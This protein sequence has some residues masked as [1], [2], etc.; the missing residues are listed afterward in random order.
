[1]K[2]I[3]SQIIFTGFVLALYFAF[4]LVRRKEMRYKENKLFI[5]VCIWSALWSFGFFGVILQTDPGMGYLWRGIGMIGTFGFLISAQFLICHLSGVKKIYCY[6]TEGFSLLGI[7]LYFFVIRKDQVVYRLGEFGMT[8]SFEPTIWNNLYTWYTVLVAFNQFWLIMYMIFRPKAQRTKILG[9]K[10]LVV[11]AAMLL[12]MVLDTIFPLFGKP[13]IPGSTIGQFAGLAV[14]YHAIL[15]VNHSR[16]TIGNMSE[17]IYYSLDI[18]ILVYDAGKELRILNDKGFTFLGV[19]NMGMAQ[20]SVGELFAL[21]KAEAFS[22]EGNSQSIDTICLYNKKNCNLTINKIYDDYGDVIGYIIIVTDLSDRMKS[23]KRLE[24]AVN[25]ADHANKAKSIFLANMSHEIR[26]PMNAIIGFSELLL[27]KDLDS[28]IRGHVED[29]KFS[30]QNL[31]TIINDILDISK[32][33]SGKMELVESNY[34]TANLLNDVRL[35]IEPQVQKKNLQFEVS[36]DENLPNEMYGDKV[37]IRGILINILNNAVKY[38]REGLVKF[39]VL[40]KE[41][42]FNRI[43]LAFRVTDTGTGI[44]EENLATLFDKFERL[45]QKVHY[46]IEGSGLGLAIAKAYVTMMGGEIKVESRYGVGST[47]TIEIEQIVVDENPIEIKYLHGNEANKNADNFMLKNTKTLVVDDNPVNLKVA[48]GILHTY[49]C[50]VDVALSGADAID[51]CAECNYDIVFMDQMMPGM[52]GPEAMWQIRR[53]NDHYKAG[54]PGKII[55]LTANAIK[56]TRE[57]LMEQGF[58]EY[59]GKPLN[60]D[61]LEALLCKFI[62]E[63]NVLWKQKNE[64]NKVTETE[65]NH[66]KDE[67]K[68]IREALPEIDVDLGL[69]HCGGMLEDYLKVLAI[70]YKYGEKQLEELRQLWDAKD[71]KGYNIKVHSLKSTS[72]NIGAKEISEEAKR[73]EEAGLREDYEYIEKNTERL[74]G[75][76]LVIMKKVKGVLIHFGVLEDLPEEKREE[77]SL[78]EERMLRPMLMNVEKAVDA[79]DFSKVFMIL[80][81]LDNYRLPEGYDQII[82]RLNTMMEDLSVE[83]IKLLLKETLEQ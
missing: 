15:F 45:D 35:I 8:Y 54:G 17:F 40:I 57:A 36:Y 77:K 4:E 7:I 28:D 60:I 67:L 56:G 10:L 71:Y 32:I 11:E 25:E 6:L 58:D 49:G 37:R 47:F 9:K 48:Q 55:V 22:F 75:E 69:S 3:L 19:Y 27:K 44:K 29:I 81:E 1:M 20:T 34:Y 79:F 23:M 80:E 63:E 83:E 26:T 43:S 18:P 51:M 72:L 70:T 64:A 21:T 24:E 62:P 50:E 66:D 61:R 33:E 30:S 31:L 68:W 59:L 82:Q 13:A 41:K 76:Y 53:L 39:E 5:H 2:Y 14:M 74:I 52:D 78:L 46:G 42:R 73:Q 12:G 38:T 16:I 65:E